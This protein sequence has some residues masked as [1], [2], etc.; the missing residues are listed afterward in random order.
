MKKLIENSKKIPENTNTNN[1]SPKSNN[2][3]IWINSAVMTKKTHESLS[4]IGNQEGLYF[5]F[6]SSFQIYSEIYL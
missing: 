6:L 5:S 4:V 2:K 3:G 1:Q